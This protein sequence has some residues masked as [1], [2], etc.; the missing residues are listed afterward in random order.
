MA[1]LDN[2]A[3]ACSICNFYKGADVGTFDPATGRFAFLFN[4][5]TQRWQRHFRL[6]GPSIEPLTAGG[7][8]VTVALLHLNS[9][10][11]IQERQM[12]LAA[13]YYP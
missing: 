1:T 13:D 12:L 3:W 8:R 2:L 9:I 11:R 7:G 4:P 10:A 5:R 6:N